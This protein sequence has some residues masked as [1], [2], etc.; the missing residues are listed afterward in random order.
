MASK[1]W[2]QNNVESESL[3]YYQR[4]YGIT[5][6]QLKAKREGQNGKCE[7]CKT[8]LKPGRQTHLDHCHKTGKIRALLCHECNLGIHRMDTAGPEWTATAIAY[9]K[10]YRDE[11]QG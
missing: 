10:R 7:I 3:K 6:E 4:T 9:L 5:P 1:R 8:D 2:Y 11:D